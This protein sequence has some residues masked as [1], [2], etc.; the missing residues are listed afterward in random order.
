MLRSPMPNL[1]SQH[2]LEKIFDE[3]KVLFGKY[4]EFKN[5]HANI[6]SPPK[7][8]VCGLLKAG[9]SSLL[10]AL[11]NNLNTEYFETG[12]ARATTKIKAL[13]INGFIYIDTPGIDANKEDEEEAWRG[14]VD[15]D[16]ILFVHN[17]REGSLIESESK[18]LEAL[19]RKQ[20]N[21]SHKLIIVFSN[22]DN[23]LEQEQGQISD[24]LYKEISGI[25]NRVNTCK[26]PILVS[27]SE[28]KIG[29]LENEEELINISG[30]FKLK[31][32]IQEKTDSKILALERNKHIASLKESIQDEIHKILDQRKRKVN[33]LKKDRENEISLLRNDL[34]RMKEIIN[35][36]M[37]Y[38]ESI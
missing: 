23:I 34:L 37:I 5:L 3:N 11:T 38:L 16:L 21:L 7:I 19:N 27:S 12:S 18:F 15:T 31:E 36:R 1:E 9:K 4:Q 35:E 32:L 24:S 22:K 30:I 13:E 25:I 6:S 8:V 2:L 20:Q 17:L 28:Y 29:K 10:N 26:D 14:L 33:L